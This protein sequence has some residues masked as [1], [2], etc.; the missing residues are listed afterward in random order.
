MNRH[1]SSWV[2]SI[3]GCCYFKSCRC[4]TWH[5]SDTKLLVTCTISALGWLVP[6]TEVKWSARL[7]RFQ[8]PDEGER[9]WNAIYTEALNIFNTVKLER[10][11]AC[12]KTLILATLTHTHILYI[13][14]Y[15]Y[16]YDIWYMD[17]MHGFN[18]VCFTAEIYIAQVELNKIKQGLGDSVRNMTS[19]FVESILI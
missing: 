1:H 3:F 12:I 8:G 18:E 14:I 17:Y 9:A 5:G 10:L 13:Y 6:G 15:I 19:R 16:I 2:I 7:K 11:T 4:W